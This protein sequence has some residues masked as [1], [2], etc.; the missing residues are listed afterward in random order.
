MK[1]IHFVHISNDSF[2]HPIR[3]REISTINSLEI[4]T[5]EEAN[6]EGNW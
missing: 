4:F 6:A 3:Q 5:E 2:F 1:N